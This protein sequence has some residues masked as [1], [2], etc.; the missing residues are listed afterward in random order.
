MILTFRRPRTAQRERL[1]PKSLKPLGPRSPLVNLRRLLLP[2]R[3]LPH[4][5]S[6]IAANSC[7]PPASFSFLHLQ[8]LHQIYQPRTSIFR[9]KRYLHAPKSRQNQQKMPPCDVLQLP[10]HLPILCILEILLQ[11]PVDLA[12]PLPTL[13]SSLNSFN[14]SCS[15]PLLNRAIKVR[16]RWIGCPTA[17]PFPHASR[18]KMPICSSR[19][20]RFIACAARLLQRAMGKRPCFSMVH[21]IWLMR[22]EMTCWSTKPPHFVLLDLK[23]CPLA[24]ARS[25]SPHAHSCI[26][27][28]FMFCTIFSNYSC[29]VFLFKGGSVP[30]LT[31]SPFDRL[32][33]LRWPKYP[34]TRVAILQSI[35]HC[36]AL[37]F[38]L[39]AARGTG[40]GHAPLEL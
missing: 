34:I 30:E 1:S 2:P 12:H 36:P 6:C 38:S 31:P 27:L 4:P 32:C 7:L 29:I 24:H 10:P 8:P 11:S 15:P 19:L 33:V 21:G 37:I 18:R 25:L 40:S 5:P 20:A 28:A 16:P 17:K 39:A 26:Y 3:P 13:P 35:S 22:T 14:G 23:V 9:T